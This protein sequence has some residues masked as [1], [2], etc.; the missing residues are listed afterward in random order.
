M[1]YNNSST[2]LR[3]VPR[4]EAETQTDAPDEDDLPCDVGEETLQMPRVTKALNMAER[5]SEII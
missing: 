5:K 2:F 1:G 4:S 3:N